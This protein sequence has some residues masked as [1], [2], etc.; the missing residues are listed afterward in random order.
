M[1]Y[2]G[3]SNTFVG[4]IGRE[5]PLNGDPQEAPNRT[6][7]LSNGTIRIA[8]ALDLRTPRPCALHAPALGLANHTAACGSRARAAPATSRQ[9]GV[10]QR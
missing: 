7:Y 6:Y 10:A 4:V 2:L 8:G 1:N 5:H 3:E 9:T